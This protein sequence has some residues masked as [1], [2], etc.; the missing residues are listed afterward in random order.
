MF[1]KVLLSVLLFCFVCALGFSSDDI[2]GTNSKYMNV[3][4][5]FMGIECGFGMEA[6]SLGFEG[7]ISLPVFPVIIDPSS[8][9]AIFNPLA[10]LKGYWKM[11]DGDHFKMN[12]GLSGYALGRFEDIKYANLILFWGPSLDLIYRFKDGNAFFISGTL[13]AVSVLSFVEGRLGNGVKL[14]K[15]GLA[16]VELTGNGISPLEIF[17]YTFLGLIPS[18]AK[19]GYRFYF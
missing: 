13:P 10:S 9:K 7:N 16:V 2:D 19:I 5:N 4:I 14:S 1:K 3:D 18:M 8:Y 15:Y 12:L 6:S 17:S 11:V